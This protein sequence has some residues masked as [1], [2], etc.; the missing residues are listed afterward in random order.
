MIYVLTVQY[1]K[2][3]NDIPL[4]LRIYIDFFNIDIN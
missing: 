1:M 2:K 3:E 4:N